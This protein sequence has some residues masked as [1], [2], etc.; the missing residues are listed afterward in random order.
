MRDRLPAAGDVHPAA[1][2]SSPHQPR[3]IRGPLA[4]EA[5]GI[6]RGHDQQ[7]RDRARL[8]RIRSVK[9]TT[10]ST[11]M[12]A[13]RTWLTPRPSSSSSMVRMSRAKCS[14]NTALESIR[15][16]R[17]PQ[18]RT[19]LH[20]PPPG[21]TATTNPHRHKPSDTRSQALTSARICPACS[22][23]VIAPRLARLAASDAAPLTGTVRGVKRVAVPEA[24]IRAPA[25]S[26]C[27]EP[28]TRHASA[29]GRKG[30]V[31]S[32]PARA[33]WLGGQGFGP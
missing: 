1:C 21:D 16:S 15:D 27:G 31:G 14:R 33:A 2:A 18:R 10:E 5:G 22:A 11:P 28:G 26:V 6:A 23:P 25:A 24:P 13:G 32:W 17:F 8:H 29:G 30:G 4:G 19:L 12:S 3:P 20:P 9:R 7:R